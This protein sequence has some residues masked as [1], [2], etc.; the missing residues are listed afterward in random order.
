MPYK[1]FCTRSWQ[2][3]ELMTTVLTI[4][5]KCRVPTITLLTYAYNEWIYN[6]YI[7]LIYMQNKVRRFFQLISS[8]NMNNF[9]HWNLWKLKCI[10][11][12][13]FFLKVDYYFL[14]QN[15]F[16]SIRNELNK[17]L[18]LIIFFL[19]LRK[20]ITKLNIKYKYILNIFV[21]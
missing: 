6:I 12:T 1:F 18:I 7:H 11:V 13:Y 9:K 16:N 15:I 4:I 20:K 8:G 2:T 5:I 17:F 21:F 19:K 10:L 14:A 3:F